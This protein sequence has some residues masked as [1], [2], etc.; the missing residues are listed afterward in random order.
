MKMT[1]ILSV[2]LA[3][4]MLLGGCGAAAQSDAARQDASTDASVL[5]TSAEGAPVA[6]T[7]A[8]VTENI[9]SSGA[10]VGNSASDAAETG[11]NA[12][13]AR[14][15]PTADE[16]TLEQKVGQL[17]ILRPD[18]LDTETEVT[19]TDDGKKR[20]SA[21]VNASIR[22]NM[23]KYQIGGVCQ[24]G[25]N[26][27]DPDQIT[28]FNQ[29]L[30][31]ASDIPLFIAVDEEGGRVARL[32]NT[33]TF[34]LPKYESAAAVG[35]QG[36]EAAYEMGNTI[37]TYIKSY[38]FNVDFAPDAD[39]N[40]NPDNPIIGTRA[41]SSDAAKAAELSSAA[42]QGLA[43]AGVLPTFKHF[44]GHGDTAED[45]HT[46][47]AYS[48]RTLEEIQ[49]CELLP[50]EAAVK[51]TPH[52]VMVS[53]I[54]MPNITGDNTPATLSAE[55]ISLIP[56]ADNTLIITDA[57]EMQAVSD[58]YSSGEAAVKALLAGCDIV[59]M[60]ADFEEAYNAVLAACQDGTI[61]AER[62]NKSVNKILNYK[63]TYL[64]TE[65]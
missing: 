34:D 46:G 45:S 20:G 62:L 19:E 6:E 18:T 16:L 49:S 40:T 51:V 27:V 28:Q 53:H 7:A 55:I 63:E 10:A 37:G 32:A 24:F 4:A 31:A 5:L 12:A 17:F 61:S 38:G 47:F 21:A 59:L 25:Q 43:D 48:Y 2:T 26:I 58:A 52:A 1:E 56:D 14:I 39:V 33:D 30:Q 54:S 23:K 65:V 29:D 22:E 35:A 57:M 8:A 36:T 41:Y 60:P 13:A 44:P 42:G 11:T 3:A 50:F 15:L 64:T 9:K